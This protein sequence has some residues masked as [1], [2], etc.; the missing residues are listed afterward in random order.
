MTT[1]TITRPDDWHIHLRQGAELAVTVDHAAKQFNR[2]VAMPNCIP[3]IT[4]IKSA[5]DYHHRILQQTPDVYKKNF[6]PLIA[7]YLTDQTS[8]DTIKQ[9]S[10][11]NNIIG[12][13]LYPRGATTNSNNG[14][15]DIFKLAN[16]IS[17]MEEYNLPLLVHGE[18]T[19]DNIDVFD[20]E[21]VFID[22]ILAPLR[23]QF[24]KLKII[25]EHITTKDGVDFV[26]DNKKNTAAT[27]TPHHLLLNRNDLL[28]G[29]LKPHYY[30]L[31]II[32]DHNN[33][34]AII[35][36]A[37]SGLPCFFAGS[38]SAPHK[39]ASKESS[40]CPAGIYH[41][42]KTTLV[43]TE[44]FDRHQ[45]LDKLEAFLSFYGADFYN[46]QRNAE[47]IT[48]VKSQNIIPE[49]YDYPNAENKLIPFWAG[50]TLS[51]DFQ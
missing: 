39:K 4:D 41:G 16:V 40:Y 34:Q 29:G 43:Y 8:V 23:S 1:L 15:T 24:P 3:P 45:K 33:Q 30:C 11:N 7:L 14:V 27:I 48:L 31:P 22:T 44:F 9:A 51:W 46:L 19:D 26:L 32:K 10:I 18:V 17:A 38:D 50:K 6:K 13:K 36:A 49:Y 25:L 12:V 37:L 28:V 21:S 35:K 2:L 20:R 47:T 5:L 42:S